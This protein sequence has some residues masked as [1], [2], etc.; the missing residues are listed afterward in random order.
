[1]FFIYKIIVLTDEAY[2]AAEFGF[3]APGTDAE[4]EMTQ[5]NVNTKCPYTG[6]EMVNPVRNKNCGHNYDMEGIQ[7]YIKQRKKKAKYVNT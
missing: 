4:V 2:S 6:M 3:P 5:E 7:Q 1:L